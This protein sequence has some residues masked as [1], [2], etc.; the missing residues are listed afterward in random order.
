MAPTRPFSSIFD[1][2]DAAQA[3]GKLPEAFHRMYHTTQGIGTALASPQLVTK[4][5][6][7]ARSDQRV[8]CVRDLVRN[9]AAWYNEQRR[10]KPQTF[11]VWVGRCRLVYL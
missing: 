6:V 4:Y 5:G 1:I 3:P 11:E 7:D 8:V 10:R 9:T 2:A